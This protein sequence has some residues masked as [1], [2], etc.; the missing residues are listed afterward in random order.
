M[1]GYEDVLKSHRENW[2]N[3]DLSGLDYLIAEM[4]KVQERVVKDL[5]I[6]NP[7][8]KIIKN[9][10]HQKLFASPHLSMI[11]EMDLHSRF[12]LPQ[13]TLDAIV[14]IERQHKQ[15][16]GEIRTMTEA[17]KIP[18]PVL[19]QFNNLKFVLD[20]ISG[21]IAA[22]ASQH[23]DWTIIDDLEEI[24]GQSIEFCESLTDEVTGEQQRQFQSLFTLILMFIDKHK[25]KGNK[26][27]RLLEVILI[28]HQL[29]GIA[30]PGLELATREDIRQ[31]NIHQ[32]TI[33]PYINFVYG[34]IKQANEYRI[35]NR[36]CV[37][38]LKPELNTLTLAKLPEDF[39]VIVIQVHHK[40][41]YVSYFDL[42]DNLPQTGWIM[43]KY[44]DKP[45]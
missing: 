37:V 42:E 14:S 18:S 11:K 16:F 28:F 3:Q 7:M 8:D 26:I 9:T 12:A 39:E 31:I 6:N 30:F 5:S 24:T 32:D 13:T 36:E 20:G 25:Q 40:W 1:A 43:K 41:V 44:L 17:I 22:I 2:N 35:T 33:V 27:L 45:V 21:E 38:K 34:Q 29:Y 10:L 4:R 15:I 23:G 19:A